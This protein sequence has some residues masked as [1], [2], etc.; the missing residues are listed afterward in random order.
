MK[1][2][3]K[4]D[5][6]PYFSFSNVSDQC[7]IG[8]DERFNQQNAR[9]L[10]AIFILFLH[11]FELFLLH[12]NLE[13]WNDFYCNCFRCVA[14]VAVLAFAPLRHK[15]FLNMSMLPIRLCVINWSEWSKGFTRYV[16]YGWDRNLKV[17]DRKGWQAR[18]GDTCCDC[19]KIRKRF[20]TTKH[21][22]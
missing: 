7:T 22:K 4:W 3:A 21:N 15:D 6:H 20:W 5:I 1:H 19:R 18:A 17:R 11:I 16:H 12:L 10:R 9:E 13:R 8:H 14:A 2:G